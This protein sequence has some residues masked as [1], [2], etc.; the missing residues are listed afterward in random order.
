MNRT[1]HCRSLVLV[2]L[3]LVLGG[4]AS[5]PAEHG[6]MYKKAHALYQADQ[7][8]QAIPLLAQLSKQ[9]PGDRLVQFWL[10]NCLSDMGDPAGARRAWRQALMAD[11]GYEAAWHNLVYVEIQEAAVLL[12]EMREH[13]GSDSELAGSL[14]R[15]IDGILGEIERYRVA[16][17]GMASSEP[18]VSHSD[19][20]YEADSAAIASTPILD[21]TPEEAPVN[22]A[23]TPPAAVAAAPSVSVAQEPEKEEK[24]PGLHRSDAAMLLKFYR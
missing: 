21:D 18:H 5:N 15:L 14:D 6:A 9:R 24:R 1:R 7:C 16:Q 19:E 8:D 3:L 20:Q 17:S 10:G 11:P 2:G 12:V 4:C 23:K 22:V 13:V